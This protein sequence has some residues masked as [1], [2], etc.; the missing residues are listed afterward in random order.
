METVGQRIKA[1]R[2]LTKT[3]QK[4]LGK[5]CGVSDVAV[6]YWEKDINVPGGESLS[7]LAKYFNTSID[8]ILYGTELE[9]NLITKM[10]RIPVIS[11]VQAGQFTECKAAEVFSEVDKWVETSLRIG[12]SSFALEVKG[13]SMTNPNGLPTI[14][15]GATVIVD[16]DAEPLNGKIVVARLD[17][18][19]EAT[20]KKLVIDGPQKF[21]VP[22]NPRYPNISINGN[23]LIIGVVK[24]VQYEL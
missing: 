24:G 15:E 21:L 12:D 8:Y 5:F 13:D 7:K 10:R 20:V 6:G 1:L 18:T 14:P 9:G 23:C 11:W 2:R 16:P 17:G 3:S 4:E 19:N 22:L